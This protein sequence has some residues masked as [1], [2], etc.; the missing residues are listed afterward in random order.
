VN[1]AAASAT[2]GLGTWAF[3]WTLGFGANGLNDGGEN[4][5]AP[6]G[7]G[8]Q[9]TGRRQARTRLRQQRAVAAL[10]AAARPRHRVSCGSWCCIDVHG[11]GADDIAGPCR[12]QFF[13]ET[14]L[15]AGAKRRQNPDKA[16]ALLLSDEGCCGDQECAGNF[17][18]DANVLGHDGADVLEDD[19]ITERTAD[20]VKEWS[21]L[22]DGQLRRHRTKLGL[23]RWRGEVGAARTLCFRQLR[24]R[25]GDARSDFGRFAHADRV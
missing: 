2:E 25:T 10:S 6:D 16:V 8:G 4:G 22:F 11:R 5:G 3:P 20:F 23:R 17:V 1:R 13:E 14:P 24:Q 9:R 15:F 18:F 19:L 7:G 12:L 21:T